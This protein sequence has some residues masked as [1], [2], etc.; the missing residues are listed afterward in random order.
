[1]S[2]PAL[3]PVPSAPRWVAPIGGLLFVVLFLLAQF[4]ADAWFGQL[5]AYAFLGVLFDLFVIF[6]AA[7]VAAM[8]LLR[9]YG[10]DPGLRRRLTRAFCIS[11]W[12][13]LGVSFMLV[14]SM[15][16]VGPFLTRLAIFGLIKAAIGALLIL[17]A[18]ALCTR[19]A[20]RIPSR[21]ARL[22]PKTELPGKPI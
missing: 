22:S 14:A 11:Y 2:A 9:S 18:V 20:K 13:V 21:R 15:P 19:L 3:E 16:N 12:L 7:F 10:R 1:M 6:L 4:P 5:G 17:G 8:P